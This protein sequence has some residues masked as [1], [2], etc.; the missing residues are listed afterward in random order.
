MTAGQKLKKFMSP[1]LRL[2]VLRRD[3]PG[4]DQDGPKAADEQW[5]QD[6][7][8][9]GPTSA[10]PSVSNLSHLR[11][12]SMSRHAPHV[13]ALLTMA[14]LRSIPSICRRG[15]AP[16]VAATTVDQEPSSAPPGLTKLRSICRRTSQADPDN[17]AAAAAGPG[18]SSSCSTAA[19]AVILTPRSRRVSLMEPDRRVHGGGGAVGAGSGGALQTRRHRRNSEDAYGTQASTCSQ[20]DLCAATHRAAIRRSSLLVERSL[21][22]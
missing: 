4:K 7:P 6:E 10:P 21:G 17:Q 22:S 20:L 19:T 14:H 3:R 11:S 16:T 5:T 1:F 18:S 12:M 15:G 13:A 8:L 2:S 9:Q